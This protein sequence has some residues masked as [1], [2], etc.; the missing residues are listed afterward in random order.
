MSAIFQ[1][2]TCLPLIYVIVLEQLHHNKQE[3]HTLRTMT[4]DLEIFRINHDA[5]LPLQRKPCMVDSLQDPP[6][7]LLWWLLGLCRS[8]QEGLNSRRSN[9]LT[10]QFHARRCWHPNLWRQW[11]SRSPLMRWH[12]RRRR[13]DRLVYGLS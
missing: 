6:H 5:L 9:R 13:Y 1:V 7:C 4:F 3:K 11:P 12:W 8:Q 2:L 10:K